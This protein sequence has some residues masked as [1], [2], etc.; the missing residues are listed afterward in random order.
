MQRSFVLAPGLILA[1]AGFASAV[2][3]GSQPANLVTIRM[4]TPLAGWGTNV[5]EVLHTSD[6]GRHWQT[7]T[8]PI[9]PDRGYSIGYLP[10]DVINSHTAWFVSPNRLGSVQIGRA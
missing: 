6:G 5:S 2:H 4:V 1:L 9:P 7:V 8:P 3:V 10:L